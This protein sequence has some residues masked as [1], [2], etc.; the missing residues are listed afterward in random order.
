MNEEEMKQKA[1]E[2]ETQKN[3]EAAKEQHERRRKTSDARAELKLA[4]INSTLNEDRALIPFMEEKLYAAQ[5][6]C[7]AAGVQPPE[8]NGLFDHWTKLLYGGHFRRTG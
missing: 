5:L 2:I 7:L 1:N 8:L 4:L 6:A 3:I